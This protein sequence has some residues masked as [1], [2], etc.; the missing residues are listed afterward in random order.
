MTVSPVS[1]STNSIGSDRSR[2]ARA[3]KRFRG[4]AGEGAAVEPGMRRTAGRTPPGGLCAG[5][6]AQP[7]VD[8]L[9]RPVAPACGPRN[10]VDHAVEHQRPH[11]P[12]EEVGVG[13]P[14]QGAVGVSGI[15]QLPVADGGRR[16]RS[17]SR[18]T[19]PVAMWSTMGPPAPRQARFSVRSACSKA[20]LL[21][22]GDRERDRR[23]GVRRFLQ[24]WKQ[25]NGVLRVDPT[26]IEPDQV[27]ASEHF[28]GVGCA[29]PSVAPVE[30]HVDARG[31]RA[32]RV[33]E[34]RPD[35]AAPARR[36]GAGSPPADLRAGASIVVERDPEGGA[37][38]ARVGLGVAGGPS[39]P[40]A[41]FGG[42]GHRRRA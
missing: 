26:W 30:D 14:E 42:L 22:G 9:G 18:A 2:S 4:I 39:Q 25:R 20:R 6:V 38:E 34:E 27:E 3:A 10:R 8:R 1:G 21:L 12:G 13:D 11:P 35:S 33:D 31:A 24:R 41:R 36:R 37:L 15:G 23:D 17:R 28:G 5:G 7:V 16:S 32:P 29:A 40:G 19:L